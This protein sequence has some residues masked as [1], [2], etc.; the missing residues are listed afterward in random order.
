MQNTSYSIRLSKFISNF[1]NPINSL[2][3]YFVYF[4][5]VN[6][7]LEQAVTEF[8][9][10]L[11]ILI[12][13]V[14]SW[15]VWNVRKGNYSNMDVSNR[16]QRKSLY[17]VIIVLIL[18]YLVFNFLI[19]KQIDYTML[20]LFLLIMMMHFSNFLIKTSMHTALNVFAAALFFT[21]N[22]ILGWMWLGIA[23][24]VGITRVILKRHT[25]PEVFVGF[26][27]ALIMS[28]AYLYTHNVLNG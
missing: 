11:L 8:L 12:I 20:F 21:E 24:I 2:F 27:L 19:D 1:F 14:I 18:C 28:F 6:Y 9:P 5:I 10:I 4:S 15:I 3:L 7:D 17:T 13:P 25:P 16:I 22:R 23:I 26:L